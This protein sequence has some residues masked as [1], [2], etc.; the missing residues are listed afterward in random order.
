[1]RDL[2]RRLL[3]GSPLLLALL[4]GPSIASAAAPPVV[5]S[6]ANLL[7]EATSWLLLLVPGAGGT[8]LAYHAVMRNLDPDEQ[9]VLRHNNAMRR[10]LIGTAI[11]T[12]AVGTVNWLSGYFR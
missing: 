2:V 10:V 3:A 7:N 6:A 12:S 8:M 5:Q 4:A 9:S 11:A 1:M